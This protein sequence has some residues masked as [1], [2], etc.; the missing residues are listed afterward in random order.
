MFTSGFLDYVLASFKVY[1]I[2]AKEK[3]DDYFVR[4]NILASVL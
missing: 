3:I 2:K 1:S 4:E